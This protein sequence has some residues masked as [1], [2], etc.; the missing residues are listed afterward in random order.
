MKKKKIFNAE[1]IA[2]K[3]A[4]HISNDGDCPGIEELLETVLTFPNSNLDELKFYSGLSEAKFEKA[5][6]WLIQ[7]GLIYEGKIS[8]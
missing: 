2:S 7:G 8:H 3:L 5:M 1:D 6:S 4:M